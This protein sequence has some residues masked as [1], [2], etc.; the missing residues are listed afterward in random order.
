MQKEQYSYR[1]VCFPRWIRGQVLR[2]DVCDGQ[3]RLP[4]GTR[5][6][7]AA[8]DE[9][10]T[11]TEASRLACASRV[12]DLESRQ[13]WL[14]RSDT[15]FVISWLRTP[16]PLAPH[17]NAAFRPIPRREVFCLNKKENNM[18]LVK[19][20]VLWHGKVSGEQPVVLRE[21]PF[22]F[23]RQHFLS[24]EGFVFSIE[25]KKPIML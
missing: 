19:S 25:D 13:V 22:I 1:P 2:R 11:A 16:R 15:Y 23:C 8:Q 12:C 14:V 10:S 3:G 6:N 18:S 4:S 24:K 17:S 21:I 7:V 5:P 9:N 20:R